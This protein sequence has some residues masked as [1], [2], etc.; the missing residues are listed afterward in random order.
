MAKKLASYLANNP[1][2]SSL[3]PILAAEISSFSKRRGNKPGRSPKRTSLWQ[4][5][6]ELTLSIFQH[7]A[8]RAKHNPLY[9]LVIHVAN[10]NAHRRPGVNGGFPDCFW[11]VPSRGYH[12][13][14]ME[15]KTIDGM[16]GPK[17]IWWLEQLTHHGHYATVGVEDQDEILAK[18]DWYISESPQSDSTGRPPNFHAL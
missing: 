16:L 6:D 18:F 14:A 13:F 4:D 9:A 10:E 12:G 11:P 8:E 5:E 2:L 3:N 15:L 17:Q 7:L 1:D